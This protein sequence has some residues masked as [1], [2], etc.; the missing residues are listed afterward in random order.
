MVTAAQ[1]SWVDLREG[2]IKESAM[3]G[4]M[5]STL[6]RGIAEAEATSTVAAHADAA[7]HS[8]RFAIERAVRVAVK[9]VDEGDNLKIDE[10][11]HLMQSAAAQE[12][13]IL[14]DAL[15][16]SIHLIGKLLSIRITS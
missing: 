14:Q 7:W 5:Q 15:H 9:A 1:E 3:A 11:I 4:R 16:D 2:M 12:W 6:S 13:T 8:V 10:L